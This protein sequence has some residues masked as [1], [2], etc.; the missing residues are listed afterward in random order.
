MAGG[1]LSGTVYLIVFAD[2]M[3]FSGWYRSPEPEPG[4]AFRTV[5][6]VY[7]TT[8]AALSVLSTELKVIL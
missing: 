6:G 5:T 3:R 8:G 7:P 2:W 4:S 1:L